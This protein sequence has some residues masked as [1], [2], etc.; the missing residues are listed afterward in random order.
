MIFWGD[1]RCL[2][3]SQGNR[4]AEDKGVLPAVSYRVS[5]LLC[6]FIPETLPPF[7]NGLSA[8]LV[9]RNVQVAPVS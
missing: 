1:Q 8:F 5:V 4:W 6:P 9:N 3:S 7:S 2:E